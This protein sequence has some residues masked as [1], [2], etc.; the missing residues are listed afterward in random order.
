MGES[1][2]LIRAFLPSFIHRACLWNQPELG[3]ILKFLFT[4]NFHRTK[5]TC[6]SAKPFLH[7][8]YGTKI[9]PAKLTVVLRH[10]E[11]KYVYS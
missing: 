11:G 6:N 1:R 2:L 3:F 4:R 9:P 10:L 8:G 5:Y 7:P